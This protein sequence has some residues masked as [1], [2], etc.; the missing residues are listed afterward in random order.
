M[1]Q[2]LKDVIDKL[3]EIYDRYNDKTY[4]PFR[5][6]ENT[7][8]ILSKICTYFYRFEDEWYDQEMTPMA[9]PPEKW[10]VDFFKKIRHNKY[11]GIL[12]ILEYNGH[13]RPDI[14][15]RKNKKSNIEDNCG[16]F[17]GSQDIIFD[18][19][20][21]KPADILNSS[22]IIFTI[23]AEDAEEIIKSFK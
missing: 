5:R 18:N 2:E 11:E 19:S 20:Y 1:R 10:M 9:D 23:S 12:C 7:Y 15:I 8:E 6:H 4:H 13:K 14:L 17:I 3:H 22:N 21:I 16:I